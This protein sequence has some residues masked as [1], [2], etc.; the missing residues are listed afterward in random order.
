MSV[1]SASSLSA[2]DVSV[3]RRVKPLPKRRRTSLRWFEVEGHI[4]PTGSPLTS[5]TY[6]HPISSGRI[7]RL[8]QESNVTPSY[9]RNS[10]KSIL[11]PARSRIVD[12]ADGDGDYTDHLRQPNNTKK[13]KVPAAAVGVVRESESMRENEDLIDE[14]SSQD[15]QTNL[16][17]KVADDAGTNHG[18]QELEYQLINTRRKPLS[19]VTLASLRLKELLK[20][21]RKMMATTIHDDVDPLALEFALSAPFA[22]PPTQPSIRAW[23]YGPKFRRRPRNRTTTPFDRESCFSRNFTF[24][25]PSP[26]GKRYNAAKKVASALQLRF[27]TELARQATTAAEFALKTTAKPLNNSSSE[28]KKV[29]FDPVYVPSNSPSADKP[30]NKP[31]KPK[32]KKPSALANASN[33]HHL[34][35]YVPSRVAHSG[36]HPA[37]AA[38]GQFQINSLGPLALKFLSATLPPRRRKGHIPTGEN[39]GASLVHPE[40]EWICPFCEYSLFYSDEAAMQRATRNRRRILARR[41]NAQERAAA[42]AN[43]P[44][45]SKSRDTSDDEGEGESEDEEDSFGGGS[46][47]VSDVPLPRGATT[48]GTRQDNRGPHPGG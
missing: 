19:L 42:A 30:S 46:D 1:F 2:S 27:Q 4:L 12:D 40:T 13:R 24:S 5:S 21:R 3:A 44:I 6:Y 23:S 48:A 39:S 29:D 36:G 15:S 22:R 47:I 10:N 35:N 18:T 16:L 45:A 28:R 17:E 8:K 11:F 31:K 7:D 43:G 25:F 37:S 38:H 32:K 20:A 14:D 34:R 33:P 41:R 26:I 9:S